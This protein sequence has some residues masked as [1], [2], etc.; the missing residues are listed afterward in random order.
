[1]ASTSVKN[2]E[3]FADA[4]AVEL[5]LNLAG[6]QEKKLSF[7]EF[8]SKYFPSYRWYK[9]CEVLVNVLQRIA[10]GE[11]KRVMVFMPPRHGKS[12]LVS[13]M[14]PAYFLYLYPEKFVGVTAF[15]SDL[16]YGFSRLAREFFLNSG[17]D[18]KKDS[19]SVK[20]WETVH[21][22]GMWAAGVGGPITG[23]GFHLG[24]IDDPIKNAE[25]AFSEK[26]RSKQKDWYNSTFYTREEDEGAILVTLTRWHEDDLAGYLL[27]EEKKAD[28]DE[29]ERW[30]ILNFEAIKEEDAQEFPQTC[31]LEPDWRCPG[32]ALERFSITKLK[33][34]R[35]K[36]EYFWNA[37]Y[38][39]RPYSLDGGI[40]KK[41]Y[42]QYYQDLPEY[43]DIIVQSWDCAFKDTDNSS[44]VVGQVWG[45]V[46][47]DFYLLDQVREKLDII[48]T[49]AAI[50]EISQRWDCSAT[51]IEDK[52]NGP[53]VIS[54][55][56]R[57]I[58]GIIPIQPQGGKIVRATA[59]APYFAAGNVW[60]PN[61]SWIGEYKTEFMRFPN[62]ANSDQVDST[63]QALTW[64]ASS[65]VNTW[66]VSNDSY[67]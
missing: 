2:R 22:G 3:N 33:R 50:R 5:G 59:V 14:F 15:G 27:D 62:S 47:A 18:L 63:S 55:L 54:M 40:F 7:R 11:L 35:K 45:M 67:Y 8:V 25:D 64:L 53:A 6:N 16:V 44:F 52:A 31:T 9:H 12:Q 29:Q 17:G 61:N 48:G 23:K 24:I 10:D 20:H 37:L 38:Q 49:I 66:S 46:G 13:R 57:E 56:S 60:V 65:Q 42:W 36:S 30:H 43:F 28:I 58:P 1:M 34:I 4:A 39:Q 32:E 26:I 19:K 51:L 41:D 21:G